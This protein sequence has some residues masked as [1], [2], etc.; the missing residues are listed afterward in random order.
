MANPSRTLMRQKRHM[1]IRRRIAGTAE[2]PRMSVCTTSKHIYIQFIDDDQGKTLTSVSTVDPEMRTQS[3][4]SDM[5]GAATL[6]KTAAERA[7]SAGI[8]KVVFDRGGFRFHG[9]IKA[10]AD[11]AREAG[12]E[13]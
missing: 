3:V 9:R 10:V 2:V 8:S 1:R 7:K 5:A 4:K 12:L 13:F 6:G 11:S